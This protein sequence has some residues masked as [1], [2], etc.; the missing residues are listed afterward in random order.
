MIG[1]VLAAGLG[2]ANLIFVALLFRRGRQLSRQLSDMR[3]ERNSEWI[4]RALQ[5]AP[6]QPAVRAAN[7]AA[8]KPP[9]AGPQP[10]RRKRHLGLYIGGL[11]AAMVALGGTV[12]NALQTP[13]GQWTA[14]A[15][16]AAA[17][18]TAITLLIATQWPADKRGPRSSAPT[19]TV[20]VSVAPPSTPAPSATGSPPA[21]NGPPAA[22]SPMAPASDSAASTTAGSASW[23]TADGGMS[24]VPITPAGSASSGG[25]AEP[26]P[27]TGRP[28][29][30]PSTPEPPVDPTPSPSPGRSGLCLALALWPV[31]DL[32]ACLAG[33]G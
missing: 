6:D 17:V 23:A 1:I 2:F 25:S 29:P 31:L 33:G 26:S 24:S 20:T 7:G 21:T 3:A 15:V 12:R 28:S 10:V 18:A 9:P 8:S 27:P 30:A 11:A 13:R 32:A 19:A 5:D 14:A 4:L 22:V 16:G